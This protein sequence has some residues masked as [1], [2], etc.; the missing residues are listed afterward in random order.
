MAIHRQKLPST[1]AVVLHTS[2]SQCPPSVAFKDDVGLGALGLMFFKSG[3]LTVVANV[4]ASALPECLTNALAS[5]STYC[6][7]RKWLLRDRRRGHDTLATAYWS[8]MLRFLLIKNFN[9]F[10]TFVSRNGFDKNVNTQLGQMADIASTAD[11]GFVPQSWWSVRLVHLS[12]QTSRDHKNTSYVSPNRWHLCLPSKHNRMGEDGATFS[13]WWDGLPFGRG[14]STTKN[15]RRMTRRTGDRMQHWR[16]QCPEWAFL[17][18]RF[19]SGQVVVVVV[20][21]IVVVAAVLTLS[22]SFT[23]IVKKGFL[24]KSLHKAWSSVLRRWSG[25]LKVSMLQ[26]WTLNCVEDNTSS[27]YTSVAPINRGPWTIP[28]AWFNNTVVPGPEVTPVWPPLVASALIL[29][30]W[31]T[32]PLVSPVAM[33]NMESEA[34]HS[35]NSSTDFKDVSCCLHRQELVPTAWLVCWR[36]CISTTWWTVVTRSDSLD[37]T[38]IHSGIDKLQGRDVVESKKWPFKKKARTRSSVEDVIVPSSGCRCIHHVDNSKRKWSRWIKPNFAPNLIKRE[39]HI[40]AF[41]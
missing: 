8:P 29:S 10:Y 23:H 16:W 25:R 36:L 18:T 4:A 31:A 38:S 19:S 12:A 40:T 13:N 39:T 34:R 33:T 2:Q 37:V 24:M 22:A 28:L 41:N 15:G 11:G 1:L 26:E 35:S 7:P 9:M 3:F 30:I 5:K 6:N 17:P 32:V 20:I 14:L 27:L 21:I